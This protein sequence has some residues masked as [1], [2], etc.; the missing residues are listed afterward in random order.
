M[1]NNNIM[2]SVAG[3]DGD[4][5]SMADS[6]S[7]STAGGGNINSMAVGDMNSTAG[8]RSI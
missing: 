2:S 5:N 4:I 1:A 3:G 7:N 8:H 6:G